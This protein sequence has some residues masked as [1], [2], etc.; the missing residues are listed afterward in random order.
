MCHFPNVK[1]EMFF[2]RH[3]R[4]RRGI[5]PPDTRWLYSQTPCLRLR[6]CFLFVVGVVVVN[7]TTKLARSPDELLSRWRRGMSVRH[8]MLMGGR[9]GKPRMSGFYWVSVGLGAP[10]WVGGM[11][12]NYWESKL[13]T[14]VWWNYWESKL[15]T[16]VWCV[17]T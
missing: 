2:F 3:K 16:R 15:W 8:E 10:G 17:I 14:R 6:K 9:I 4:Q 1:V 7:L 5:P 12:W 13:W 11:G